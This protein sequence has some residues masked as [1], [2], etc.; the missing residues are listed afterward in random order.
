MHESPLPATTPG[1]SR[2][3]SLLLRQARRA[4][5][6]GEHHLGCQAAADALALCS[7]PRFRRQRDEALVLLA[8]HSLRL[9]RLT[10]AV[11]YGLEAASVLDF[12]NDA[13]IRA[14]VLCTVSMA[15]NEMG[16]GQDALKY[17][18]EA[19]G[20]A[21]LCDDPLL[22]SWALNRAGLASFSALG[23]LEQC[24]GLLQ[25]AESQA[26]LAADDVACFSALTNLGVTYRAAGLQQ[27]VLGNGDEAQR[28]FLLARTQFELAEQLARSGNNLHSLATAS[29][30][31][32]EIHTNL[33][34][35]ADSKAALARAQTLAEEGHFTHIRRNVDLAEATLLH[36]CGQHQAA[37]A[38]LHALLAQNDVLE[39]DMKVLA[40]E[41]LYRLYKECGEF[42]QALV[43]LE[44]LRR[45]EQELANQR[46]S[47]QGWAIRKEL[48]ITSAQ[49]ATERE[50]LQAERERLRAARLEAEKAVADARMNELE[51]AALV[52][53]LT[54]VG[55]RRLLDLEGPARLARLGSE[56]G[57]LAVVVLDLDH[58]KSINDRFGH[59]V[60]DETLTKV[61]QLI[62]LR[63]RSSDLVTRYGGE[64]FVLLLADTTVE[65]VLVC[66]E[67]LRLAIMDY[68][69]QE[70]H[71][72]LHVTASFGLHWCDS[73]QSW[74]EALRAADVALYR[75]KRNGRNRL[76]LSGDDEAG[77]TSA[78]P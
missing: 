33:G 17:A 43:E 38:A 60:G 44:A 71:P 27:E 75:A 16:L 11:Q 45:I 20:G 73:P 31:L 12:V 61:A 34:N 41:S 35:F 51:K 49:L 28:L 78:A 3:I 56:G 39:F 15:C 47:T 53:P 26:R 77:Q 14:D 65:S 29:I 4:R 24:V 2:T 7:L 36:H 55:N 10:D 5:Q 25:Q 67:R 66:C 52:D 8:L 70:V 9:G 22:L 64:E 72:L 42:Q 46:S 59:A 50:R 30:N 69:W 13:A 37:A 74:D 18:L 57:G 21:R 63:T 6:N 48:E 23:D 54:G 76:Q 58:F 32:A 19:L 1:T 62:T 68:S 40:H